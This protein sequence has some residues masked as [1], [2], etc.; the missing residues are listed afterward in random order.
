MVADTSDAMHPS[1]EQDGIHPNGVFFDMPDNYL[2]AIEESLITT[3]ST[4]NEIK[5]LPVEHDYYRP[6]LKNPY[7]KPF[8]SLAWRMDYSRF[9][10]GEDG[11]D[12]L[13][14]QT[15]KR[16]EVI[17]EGTTPVT[18]ILSYRVRYLRIPPDIVCDEFVT[19]N[20]RHCILDESLHDE[21]VDE[22]VKIAIATTTQESYQ[23]ADK[24]QKENEF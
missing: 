2:Y 11:D 8:A 4:P 20:Q 5:V 18:S 15:S 21:I 13:T 19:S 3:A 7:K 14:G 24:E 6:N 17:V 9:D 10:Y 22:A 12:A 1:T 23:I 16:N